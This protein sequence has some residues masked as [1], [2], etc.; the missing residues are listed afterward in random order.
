M[1]PEKNPGH[2]DDTIKNN[3]KEIE[4]IK[5]LDQA[6]IQIELSGIESTAASKAAWLISI[7][8][9]IGGFLFGNDTPVR[10]GP[11]LIFIF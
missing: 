2:H 4:N 7:I 3:F 6:N 9:S 11:P 5:S 10:E 1:D 8:V